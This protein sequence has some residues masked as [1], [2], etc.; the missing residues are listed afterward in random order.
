[1][2]CKYLYIN[3]H[4][5]S[6]H[7]WKQVKLE[8]YSYYRIRF[9]KCFD[10]S[11][12]PRDINKNNKSRVYAFYFLLKILVLIT[13]LNKRP[14]YSV[15][16]GISLTKCLFKIK[17]IKLVFKKQTIDRFSAYSNCNRASRRWLG[18][19]YRLTTIY[20]H[21]I[22]MYSD[23]HTIVAWTIQTTSYL[24]TLTVIEH[25]GFGWGEETDLLHILYVHM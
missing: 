19:C 22:C 2:P 11:K 3:S 10:F 23:S 14:V 18:L 20:A 12:L 15:F 5:V 6:A 7:K 17:L 4:C 8:S 1:M 24:R 13:Y 25:L 9:E 21:I 16:L